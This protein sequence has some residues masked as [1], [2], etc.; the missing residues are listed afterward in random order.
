MESGKYSDE[1]ENLR[2]KFDKHQQDDKHH[3]HL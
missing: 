2:V 1:A 3:K